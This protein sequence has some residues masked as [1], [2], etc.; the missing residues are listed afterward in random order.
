MCRAV[1]RGASRAGGETCRPSGMPLRAAR[2]A[3]AVAGR[4]H[5]DRRWMS[6]AARA[7]A[8]RALLRSFARFGRPCG[9]TR[10]IAIEGAGRSWQPQRGRVPRTGADAA[11]G[12]SPRDSRPMRA[13][14]LGHSGRHELGGRCGRSWRMCLQ[15]WP[16]GSGRG[17]VGVPLWAADT[18]GRVVGGR[19][20]GR[21][22]TGSA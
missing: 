6:W 20:G 3:A 11:G 4:S 1:H 22:G 16:P 7:D 19:R 14:M 15:G 13:D 18:D 5:I 12:A 2:K 10:V 21:R 17:T 9:Q 8:Q